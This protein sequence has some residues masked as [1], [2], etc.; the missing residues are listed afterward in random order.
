MALEPQTTYA[1]SGADVILTF[2]GFLATQ[3]GDGDDAISVEPAT[4]AATMRIGVGGSAVVSMQQDLSGTVRLRCLRTSPM[5][6][7]LQRLLNLQRQTGVGHPL[8][9]KDPRGA[10]VHACEQA[11][12]MQQPQSQHGKNASDVEWMIACPV[13]RSDQGGY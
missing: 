11:F 8:L 2:G 9:V 7:H 12:I 5:N 1:Y 4:E 13:L 10:E 3:L 6:G